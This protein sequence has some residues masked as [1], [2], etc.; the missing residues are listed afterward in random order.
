M[1]EK[2]SGNREESF[3]LAHDFSSSSFLSLDSII[4]SCL[5]GGPWVTSFLRR[6]K[7]LSGGAFSPR[8]EPSDLSLVV[9]LAATGIRDWFGN[10]EERQRQTNTQGKKM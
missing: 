7:D 8:R 2:G 6:G 5:L 4:W 3:A 1:G 10:G 9:P